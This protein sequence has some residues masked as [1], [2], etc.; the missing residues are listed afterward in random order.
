MSKNPSARLQTFLF[1]GLGVVLG[2]AIAACGDQPAK[3]T[4]LSATNDTDTPLPQADMITGEP[5]QFGVLSIDSA[6]S[7]SKR[8]QPLL[9]A[10]AQATQ[11]PF[12]LVSLTQDSQFTAVAAGEVDFITNNPLAAVQVQRLHDTQFLV[13]SSRPQT[14]PLF[15]GLIIVRADSDI[16]TLEDLRGKRVACVDFQTA[17]A[18]CIFQIQH[19]LEHNIDP[20]K[21]FAQFEE[22]SSQD[23]I[24]LAV[25]NHTLDAGF[26]RTGQLEKMLDRGILHSA[27]ELRILDAANDDFFY[28]HTTALYPEWPIAALKDTDPELSAAVQTVLLNLPA[29]H[30]ALQAAKLEG[31]LPVAD[32]T[33]IET[34]IENLHLKSWDAE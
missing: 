1:A 34:L 23:N 9:D 2:L 7:V 29:D 5:V 8:Y 3:I 33:P 15:S 30:P 31:F 11:R 12:Q 24:V 20:F 19:L 10:L 21:E 16:N 13:T 4:T 28:V 14:G 6:V 18:G 27:D 25:L 32:Y 17:A 22:T 26:I